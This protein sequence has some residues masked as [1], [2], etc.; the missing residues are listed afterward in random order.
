[1]EAAYALVQHNPHVI[2]AANIAIFIHHK[3]NTQVRDALVSLLSSG[4]T[5]ENIDAAMALQVAGMPVTEEN[6]QYVISHHG[7]LP[8]LSTAHFH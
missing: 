1:M 8:L 2:T 5:V 7:E 6:V 3:P 4:T